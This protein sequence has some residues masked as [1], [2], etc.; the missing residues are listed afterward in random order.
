MTTIETAP[1]SPSA[2]AVAAFIPTT[3]LTIEPP[4][5][6]FDGHEVPEFCTAVRD[7]A[8]LCGSVLRTVASYGTAAR[9]WTPARPRE[10]TI[11]Q[12][13]DATMREYMPYERWRS[14]VLG[15]PSD[16]IATLGAEALAY[17]DG[18]YDAEL[19][20]EN[21]VE[22]LENVVE[23][24]TIVDALMLRDAHHPLLAIVRAICKR[25]RAARPLFMQSEVAEAI[26]SDELLR[27]VAWQ[28]PCDVVSMVVSDAMQSVVGGERG[29]VTARGR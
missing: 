17:I 6:I 25:I 13:L 15:L 2:A 29:W 19:T 3:A 8:V 11:E 27:A 22:F 10:L 16:V 24:E 12:L 26:A 1:V 9:F 21:A 28:T 7:P 20:A 18:I 5:G 23:L 14:W 4:T